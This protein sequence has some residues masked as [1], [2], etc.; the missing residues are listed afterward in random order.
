VFWYVALLEWFF[1]LTWLLRRLWRVVE[2]LV[3]SLLWI[4]VLIVLVLVIVSVAR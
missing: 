2:V 1:G 4:L 3:V